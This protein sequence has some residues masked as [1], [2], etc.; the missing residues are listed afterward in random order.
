MLRVFEA[1]SGIGTQ[2]M[3]LRNLGIEHEVVA[4]AEI[5]K[6]ALLSY[7]AIHCDMTDEVINSYDKYPCREEIADRL[8]EMNIGYDFKEEQLEKEIKRP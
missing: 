3:A 7:S 5:N 2:R 1:F 8:S 4:I 6:E